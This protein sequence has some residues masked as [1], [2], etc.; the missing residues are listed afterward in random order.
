[1]RNGERRMGTG[2]ERLRYF[3]RKG[4]E[5]YVPS[6]IYFSINEEDE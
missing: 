1:M 2:G 5:K 6:W 3:V 4:V